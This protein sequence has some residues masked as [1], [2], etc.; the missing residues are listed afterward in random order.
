MDTDWHERV[1]RVLAGESLQV[2]FQ[3]VYALDDGRLVVVEALARFTD[4]GLVHPPDVWFAQAARFGLHVALELAAIELAIDTI[5]DQDPA[6]ELHVNASPDTLSDPA[7][8]TLAR[9]LGPRPMTVELT[10]HVVIDDYFRL[11]ASMNQLRARGI[12]IA[13]D[14]VG[15]GFASLRHI[16]RL[17]PDIIKFNVSLTQGLRQDPIRRALATSLT[18]FARQADITLI[19]ESIEDPADLTS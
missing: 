6:V 18:Q 5:S 12:R 8:A 4:P 3:P 15:A 11:Q 13:V 14:D 1:R 17:A 16:V 19:A 9:R 10:E 7:L 2:V